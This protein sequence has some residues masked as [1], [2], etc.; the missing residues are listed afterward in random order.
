MNLRFLSLL[1]LLVF[2][3]AA[4]SNESGTPFE[5]QL[6]SL[7]KEKATIESKINDLQSKLGTKALPA[8]AQPVTVVMAA[9]QS[10][11]HVVDAKGE[12]DAR[13]SL[14]ITPQMPGRITR[15]N[16]AN[17]QAVKKG[18]LLVEIDAEIIRKGIAEVMTQ[19]EF[20]ITLFEKQ[21]RIFDQKAG[22]EIQCLSAKN[23][24]ESLERRL[25]SLNEQLAMSRVIAPT[26]GFADNVMAK[27][28]ENVAPGMP[29]LTVVNVSDMRVIVDLAESFIGSVTNGDPVT[30][31]FPEVGDSLR[32]R[33]NMVAKSVNPV[34]RTFRVEIFVRPVPPNLR[35]NTTCRVLIND[36]TI[37]STIGM[38]LSAVLHD[39]VGAYVYVVDSKNSARRREVKTGLT[40]G[41]NVQIVSGV[42]LGENVI[43]RGAVDVADGQIVRTVK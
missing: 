31:F 33:I 15:V 29:L 1:V 22:S 43:V 32:T 18:Q 8:V 12:V 5:K 6:D 38:P 25:E 24:K 40:S 41:G 30:I 23:Q 16:V 4:C 11:V 2:G 19:L 10:F 28:G 14:R 42:S 9:N 27:V 34:S 3:L 37:A 7:R 17:G 13:S 26:S 35:P 21:K 36:V 20:S 39:N